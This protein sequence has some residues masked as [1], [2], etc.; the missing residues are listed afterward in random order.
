MG[1]FSGSLSVK[2]AVTLPAVELAVK[3]DTDGQE[4]VAVTLTGPDQL[5]SSGLAAYKSQVPED[6][7]ETFT[8]ISAGRDV[9]VYDTEVPSCVAEEVYPPRRMTIEPLAPKLELPFPGRTRKTIVLLVL[10]ID[11]HCTLNPLF[12]LKPPFA[13]MNWPVPL[14]YCG[15]PSVTEYVCA[16]ALVKKD[17]H[18]KS[19]MT[20]R[21]KAFQFPWFFSASFMI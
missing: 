16:C 4:F 10:L 17:R 7:P 2:L 9:V 15:F 14:A 3:P 12:V 21:K 19:S 11:T 13:Q 5:V 8:V 18:A 6:K 20:Q 1:L